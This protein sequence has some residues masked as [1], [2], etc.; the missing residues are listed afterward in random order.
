MTDED[1]T[2]VPFPA[3]Q[4]FDILPPLHALLSRL[5]SNNPDKTAQQQPN[6]SALGGQTLSGE[7]VVG[8]GGGGGGGAG[9]SFLDPKVLLTEASAIKIR[10]QKARV[11]VAELPDVDRTV[12]EQLHEIEELEAK[13]E[14]LKA[15]VGEFGQ[16][17]TKA[18]KEGEIS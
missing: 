14:K 1:S 10:V 12:D 13:I 2:T 11:A 5:V 4:I 15:V 9:V 7:A 6:G 18:M 17:S 8:G 16:R 3:P